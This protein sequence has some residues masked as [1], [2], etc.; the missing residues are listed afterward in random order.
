MEMAWQCLNAVAKDKLQYVKCISHAT[1]ND[2]Y[3]DGQSRHTWNNMKADF[4]QVTYVHISDQNANL[5]GG[6]NWS[7]LSSMPEVNGLDPSAWTW[8]KSRDRKNGDVSDVGMLW[9]ILTGN[10]NA[11]PADFERRFKNPVIPVVSV[12]TP[13]VKERTN[14]GILTK[15]TGL[16]RTYDIAGRI[17]SSEERPA[18]GVRI[19]NSAA[20]RVKAAKVMPVQ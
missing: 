15:L 2:T 1:W 6:S 20:G 11:R 17:V 13:L 7:F 5:G 4:P 3:T 10:E 14:A 19:L 8:M 9:Y 16:G 18:A 12:L